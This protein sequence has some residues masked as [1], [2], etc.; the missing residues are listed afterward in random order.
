[1][2]NKKLATL[3]FDDLISNGHHLECCAIDVIEAS[4]DSVICVG[5]KEDPSKPDWLTADGIDKVWALWNFQDK[6]GG[7][8]KRIDAIRFIQKLASECDQT[9]STSKSLEIREK[10]CG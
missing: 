1:M 7:H 10:Y 5:P 6:D 8:P 3:I 9:I 4:I 2:T